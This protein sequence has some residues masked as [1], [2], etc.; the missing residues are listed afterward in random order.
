MTYAEMRECIQAEKG[1]HK[2]QTTPLVKFGRFTV[3]MG[4]NGEEII[5]DNDVAEK[6]KHRRWSIGHGYAVS[7]IKYTMVRLH[8][9]VMAMDHEEKPDGYYVDHINQDKLDNRRCNLRFVTPTESSQN[10]PLRSVNTSGYT[11]VSQTKEGRWKAYITI[12]KK[13]IAL[14]TYSTAEEAARV[15]MEAESRL[16]FKT[17]PGTVRDKLKM[18]SGE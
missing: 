11:G 13:R 17:R 8:D 3:C 5:V 15:R 4:T 2:W 12:D 10:L 18:A 16:G 1:S 9:V 6:I 14:G 7:N